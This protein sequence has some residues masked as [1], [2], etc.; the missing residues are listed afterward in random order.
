MIAA[1]DVE[2]SVIVTVVG[3]QAFL[4]R[5]LLHL[6]AQI[7]DRSIE[8]IVAFDAATTD[9]SPVGHEFPQVVFHDLGK[10]RTVASPGTFAASHELYDRQRAQGLAI[11]RGGVIAI[12]EDYAIVA[13][14]WI[15]QVLE[16]HRLPHG[17]VGGA[18]EHVG[19]GM[20]NWA[21]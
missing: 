14:D 15:D 2:L 4:R 8:V 17:V 12:I 6:I 21:V 20:L 13:S 16:A 10:N 7:R 11:A 3:G 18:V 1:S 9:V 19:S 5:C